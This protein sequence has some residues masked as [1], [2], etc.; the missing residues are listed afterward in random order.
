MHTVNIHTHS[1][2]NILKMKE[3]KW[4]EPFESD[5]EQWTVEVC[6][7]LHLPQQQIKLPHIC[8]PKSVHVSTFYQLT[9]RLRCQSATTLE[10]PLCCFTLFGD[11]SI[12]TKQPL[13]RTQNDTNKQSPIWWDL[14]NEIGMH[15]NL[16]VSTAESCQW[17]RVIAL[18]FS[19]TAYILNIRYIA[20]EIHQPP[21]SLP[22]P[23][24]KAPNNTHVKW[25]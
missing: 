18:F 14:Q 21:H 12:W 9:S 7:H 19:S 4:L 8:I 11:H 6:L 16:R 25:S 23:P 17:R 13:I 2:S 24:N 10:P 22:R 15:E 5:S 3:K 20:A 1:S